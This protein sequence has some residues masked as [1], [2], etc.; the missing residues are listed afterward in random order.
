VPALF[1]VYARPMAEAAI[2][3]LLTALLFALWPLAR[4]REVRAAGLFRDIVSPNAQWPARR[5][6][7]IIGGLAVALGRLG[8]APVG[9]GAVRGVV[10]RRGDRGAGGAVH[11]GAAGALGRAAFCALARGAGQAGAASGAG[12]GRRAGRRDRRAQCCRSGS[13]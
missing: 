5:F 9:R 11:R 2:Y 8:C 3:G 6:L 13:G 1:D 10:R 12:L 4:A 7:W